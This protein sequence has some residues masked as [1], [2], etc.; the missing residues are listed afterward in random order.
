MVYKFRIL[1]Q[2]IGYVH[3]FRGIGTFIEWDIDAHL[4]YARIIFEFFGIMHGFKVS[5]NQPEIIGIN[6]DFADDVSTSLKY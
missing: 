1:L 2:Y 3:N 6:P 5:I 4:D